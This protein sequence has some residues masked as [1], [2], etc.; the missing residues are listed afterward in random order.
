MLLYSLGLVVSLLTIVI[1]ASNDCMSPI[2]SDQ[3]FVDIPHMEAV[4]FNI[5]F[6]YLKNFDLAE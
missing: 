2:P 1:S 5:T 6:T 4:M 3:V